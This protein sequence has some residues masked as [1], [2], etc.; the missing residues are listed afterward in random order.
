MSQSLYGCVQEGLRWQGTVV[1]VKHSNR[2]AFQV[3]VLPAAQAPEKSRQPEQA[4]TDSHRHEDKEI[5]HACFNSLA[6]E[7]SS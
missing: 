1:V 2:S 4:Q 6:M 7:A 3:F 5:G